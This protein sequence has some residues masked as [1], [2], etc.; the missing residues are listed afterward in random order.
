SPTQKITY[1]VGKWQIMNLLGQYRDR[2]GKDFRLGEFHDQLISYGSL[3]LS[4]VT[5]LMLDDPTALEDAL[6]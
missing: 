2:R 3:P 6:R 5:Y 4:V 1:M